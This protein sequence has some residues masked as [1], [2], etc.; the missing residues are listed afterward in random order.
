MFKIIT[1]E[2]CRYCNLAK[3]ALDAR[4]LDYEEEP[5]TEERRAELFVVGLRTLPQIYFYPT[6]D[7]CQHVGGYTEL[8]KFLK[9]LD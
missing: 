6:P 2:N 4:S 7:T 3:S 9:T 8:V 1:M 5:V